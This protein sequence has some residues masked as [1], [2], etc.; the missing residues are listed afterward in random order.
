FCDVQSDW[1]QPNATAMARAVAAAH[2]QGARAV[3]VATPTTFRPSNVSAEP[4]GDEEIIR[5]KSGRELTVILSPR[6]RKEVTASRNIMGRVLS[7]VEWDPDG[8]R[9]SRLLERDGSLRRLHV[10]PDL[11]DDAPLP[12][13]VQ[14]AAIAA[15][16]VG[17]QAQVYEKKS[18]VLEGRPGTSG[19]RYDPSYDP[20]LGRYSTLDYNVFGETK[21]YERR[22][23]E[24]GINLYGPHGAFPTLPVAQVDRSDLSGQIVI[25]IQSYFGRGEKADQFFGF[26][27][28]R[29]RDPFD[30]WISGGEFLATVASNV[31]HGD[32]LKRDD[33]SHAMDVALAILISL[34]VV[35]AVL[36]RKIWQATLLCLATPFLILAILQL[37]FVLE[38]WLDA[39][40]LF[41]SAV[42][43]FCLAVVNRI[44]T[45]IRQAANLAQYQSPLLAEAL[46]GRGRPEF[47]ERRQ[48]AAAL[49]VDVA[50]FTERCARIGPEASVRF[51]RRFHAEVERAAL[52]NKG[53]VE[54][55][56]GD[57]AMIIFGLPEVSPNDASNA[58]ACAQD[59]V[60][61]IE[62]LSEGLVKEGEAP[63]SIRIGAHYGPVMAAVLGGEAQR[64]VS[65]TGD[66]VNAASR[67]QAVAKKVQSTI[68]VSDALLLAANPELAA[69]FRNVGLYTLR[70]QKDPLELWGI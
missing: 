41:L 66:V 61:A 37:G 1:I 57:G 44:S 2:A 56:A 54:Q 46:S 24:F 17:W 34:Y 12:D 25:I 59:L 4:I 27:G 22:A 38:V 32:A 53:V 33:L 47:D 36:R 40:T 49:F 62:Q 11:M 16:N 48:M 52:A 31:A 70:G 69:R 18:L 42:T 50:S 68:V 29:Y 39:T 60:S 3:L 58:I 55:F 5:T 65:V 30:F 28:N 15:V 9:I 14:L 6:V 20:S 23:L 8:F 67:L 35:W 10:R 45:R 21:S 7:P 64:H 51:L 26:D 43:A 63:L 13:L 19:P